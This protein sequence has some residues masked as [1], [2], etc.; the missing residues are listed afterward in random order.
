MVVAD[1]GSEIPRIPAS[2]GALLFDGE[3]RLLILNPTYKKR[4]TIPGGQI[5]AGGETPWQACRREA[6]EECGIQIREGRLVC[7][8]FRPA[9]REDRPG[10][11]RFLFHCGT[12]TDEQIAGITLQPE[13]I[14]EFRFAALDEAAELLSG[15][16]RRR[17][18]VGA[19]SDRCR[20]LEDGRPVHGVLG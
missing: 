12:L 13:E 14:S 2:A 5:E 3:G 8:D 17:M 16:V 7:V 1:P 4:W 19:T 15:P 9:K 18:L 10:G 6:L 11:L 20:Y